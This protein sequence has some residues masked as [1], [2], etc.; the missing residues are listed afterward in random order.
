MAKFRKIEQISCSEQS[1]G[2]FCMIRQTTREGKP[3]KRG[4][5]HDVRRVRMED[6]PQSGSAEVDFDGDTFNMIPNR[7]Y[8]CE[9]S[10][11]DR[12]LTCEKP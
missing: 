7:Q 9:F 6:M 2:T 3:S 4:R 11:R 1:D 8:E 12:T 10:E 5:L